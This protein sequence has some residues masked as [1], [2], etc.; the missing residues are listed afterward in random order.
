MRARSAPK[1][2]MFTSAAR[3]GGGAVRACIG[4]GRP[5]SRPSAGCIAARIQ[6][7]SQTSGRLRCA[8]AAHSAAPLRGIH[9]S[10][11]EDADERDAVD[12]AALGALLQH[13]SHSARREMRRLIADA[14]PNL[15]P[16]GAT[17]STQ[18]APS[19]QRAPAHDRVRR[20][21]DAGFA[22][23]ADHVDDPSRLIAAHEVA[24]VADPE[25]ALLMAAH[26]LMFGGTLTRLGT[27]A[28]LRAYG[29]DAMDAD[30]LG[31]TGC[32]AMSE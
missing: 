1:Q 31:G 17:A 8:A 9:A 13:D 19:A 29:G 32:F 30:G 4:H 2:S 20:L 11:H 28:T 23:V 16:A 6:L 27:P 22:R 5:P 15:G 3:R 26:T 24:A 25:A 7:D 18:P 14:G 10:A 12:V 21:L